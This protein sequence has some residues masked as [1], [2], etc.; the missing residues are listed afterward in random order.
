MKRPAVWPADLEH[1]LAGAAIDEKCLVGIAG[2]E[3]TAPVADQLRAEAAQR[4]DQL[5][6]EEL[7]QILGVH[8]RA[9]NPAGLVCDVAEQSEEG[10]AGADADRI[11]RDASECIE[12]DRSAA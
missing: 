12:R 5:L 2:G 4:F 9:G 11:Y 10:L 8:R 6:D 1:D 7:P 3:R